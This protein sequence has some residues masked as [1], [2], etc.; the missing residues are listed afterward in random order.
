MA[1]NDSMMMPAN[2]FP[3][4]S[5]TS[6]KEWSGCSGSAVPAATIMPR[7]AV[8]RNRPWASDNHV[9]VGAKSV[10]FP[11]P[12]PTAGEN[13]QGRKTSKMPNKNGPIPSDMTNSAVISAVKKS[14]PDGKTANSCIRFFNTR[15]NSRATFAAKLVPIA[16]SVLRRNSLRPAAIFSLTSTHDAKMLR[17]KPILA[18]WASGWMG[19]SSTL[20]KS[21]NWG[22]WCT[23]SLTCKYGTR[24][25]SNRNDD[26][27][28]NE[29]SH[30]I[31]LL[32]NG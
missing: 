11:R 23:S 17:E 13:Q 2:I 31:L 30:R 7:N 3:R 5:H 26:D 12:R 19:R 22:M 25:G 1:E 9:P 29:L 6:S 10:P 27:V 21:V 16:R 28:V 20:T 18:S 15:T 8:N 24:D 32:P 4:I 14:D